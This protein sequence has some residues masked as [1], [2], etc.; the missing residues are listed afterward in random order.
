M[1]D[2]VDVNVLT[3][4]V[5][6]NVLMIHVDDNIGDNV[7]DNALMIRVGNNIDTNEG[8]D[9]E[10]DTLILVNGNVRPDEEERNRQETLEINNS[11]NRGRQFAS[12]WRQFTQVLHSHSTN[13]YNKCGEDIKWYYNWIIVNNLHDNSSGDA[14]EIPND[15]VKPT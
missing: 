3:I 5:D 8:D 11:F 7:D 1:D 2:D 12:L 6:G 13:E 14:Y 10:T 4:H 9:N 15:W